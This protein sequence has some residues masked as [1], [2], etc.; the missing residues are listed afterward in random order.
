MPQITFSE[1]ESELFN[2]RF[3]RYEGPV[4]SVTD[5]V[6]QINTL[7]L[8]FLR[9]KITGADEGLIEWLNNAQ[10][11]WHLLDIHR[12]YWL[13]T[14]LTSIVLNNDSQLTLIQ[15][16]P[17]KAS[18]MHQIVYDTFSEMPM[19]FFKH[20]LIDQYFP[21]ELQRKNVAQYIST[22]YTER[23]NPGKQS[24]LIA[25]NGH[26]IGCGAT[27][28]SPTEA[29]TVYIGLL[30]EHRKKSLYDDVIN[31]MQYTI[32]QNGARYITGSARLH[33][34]SSQA[35]FERQHER[36]TRH[37]YVVML[38]PMLSMSK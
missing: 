22:H 6:A 28:F 29:Y 17:D 27:N 37:D 8:D 31:R 7:E 16:T 26:V 15:N 4:F 32:Q 1:K 14:Q 18:I 20:H 19:G 35:V 38:I 23:S 3:G 33:N 34:L 12:Y 25:K 21:V 2:V 5:L 13:D 36:Y 24:W 9:L 10:H 11:P 30:P